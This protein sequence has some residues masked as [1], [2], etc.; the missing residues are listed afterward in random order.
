[1]K[2][3]K[4]MGLLPNFY[5]DSGIITSFSGKDSV[6]LFLATS[7]IVLPY[8]LVLHSLGIHHEKNTCEIFSYGG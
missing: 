7:K 4:G 6:Y 3:F 5:L 1:L 2:T 8:Y